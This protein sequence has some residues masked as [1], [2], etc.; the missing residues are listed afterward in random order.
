MKDPILAASLT[1]TGD[2]PIAVV[3]VNYN[4]REHLRAC[5]ATVLSETPSEVVVVDNASS[6]GSVEM[7]QADYP[8]V[9]L[10]ANETNVGY[11]AA[12]NQAIAS[13]AA[14]Y[15]LL[16][17][18]D[19]LLQS[20]ALRALS[21]YLDLHPPA[22]IVGPRLANPQG[23]Q[24][25]SCHPFPT[26]LNTLVHMSMLNELIGHVP[27]LRNHYLNPPPRRA[28][29]VPWVHGAALA[30]RREP[31]EMVGGFD[32]A[33]FMYSEEVDLCYRLHDTGWQ[34]HFAPVTTVVHVGGISTMQRR[35]EMGV[36]VFASLMQFYER[37]SSWIHRV[38]VVLIVKCLVLARLIRDML[39]LCIARDSATRAR[40]AADVAAWQ[41]V[42]LGHWRERAPHSPETSVQRDTQ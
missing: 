36:Q 42:L 7:V 21:T 2:A 8:D 1:A 37:H 29:A 32:E 25:P 5:L 4:T 6:D 31:F 28:K 22:A 9:V 23:K 14:K 41:S 38:E 12:A 40:L 27:F 13:C 39:H 11:G 20:G 17:N 34:I 30:I 16:L 33:F 10:H 24:Q 26:P 35:T 19:T 3:I 15:I 18:A